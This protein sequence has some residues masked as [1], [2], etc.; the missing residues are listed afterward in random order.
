MEFSLATIHRDSISGKLYPRARTCIFRNFWSQIPLHHSAKEAME[1]ACG[2]NTKK[3]T[4]GDRDNDNRRSHHNLCGAINEKVFSSDLF[5][6]TTDVRMAKVS[7]LTSLDGNPG[8]DVEAVF[9]IKPSSTQWRVK[10]KAFVIGGDPKDEVEQRARREIQKGMRQQYPSSEESIQAWS[11]EKEIT[12]QFANLNPLMR[13]SF[14][15]PPPGTIRSTPDSDYHQKLKLGQKV[16]SPWDEVARS[17]FR[18]V[19]IKPEDVEMV[20][21]TA[22][23]AALRVRWKLTDGLDDRGTGWKREDLWP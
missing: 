20:D 1:T 7:D 5:T 17:N 13:G 19:V 9:W 15:N 6:F 11:W 10:G 4:Y 12:A 18:V 14:R 2:R 22:P 16:D 21:L 23:D 8:A 3:E